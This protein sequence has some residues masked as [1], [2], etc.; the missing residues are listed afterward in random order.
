RMSDP[1]GRPLSKV[2]GKVIVAG[3]AN[4]GKT[5]LVERFVNDVYA[6]DDP[7]HG[8]TIGTDAYN[9]RVFV[10]QTTEVHLFI[11]D[12][13]GQERFADMAAQYYRVGEVCLLCWDM[14]NMSTFDN[15]E[16]WMK[17]VQ[18]HN[19]NCSFILVGT[20]EDTGPEGGGA[21][22][23]AGQRL[24]R[25]ARHTVLPHERAER[26]GGA[27][28][29]FLFHTVAEKCARRSREKQLSENAGGGGQRLGQR[30][31]IGAPKGS[32]C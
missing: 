29:K 26:R 5:C 31:G 10:D 30:S 16:W 1:P 18:E 32:C 8:A 25:G 9:K 6:A 27:N 24:V 7:T 15:A 2:T 19:D 28:I 3:R 20:K 21:R 23:Q 4:V 13:A 22:P 12:T 11:Y 14:S 17:R